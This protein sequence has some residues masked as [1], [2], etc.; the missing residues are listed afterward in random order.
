MCV[1]Q[2]VPPGC[3]TY[4]AATRSQVQST[5]LV[6][7]RYSNGSA[8]TRVD[9]HWHVVPALACR[10]GGR[11]SRKNGNSAIIPEG[12]A[13]CGPFTGGGGGGARVGEGYW[14]SA[15]D[16]ASFLLVCIKNLLPVPA[17][18]ESGMAADGCH[19]CMSV[20]SQG[21]SVISGKE[22]VCNVV[23]NHCRL[24]DE[25]FPLG[26]EQ[27]IRMLLLPPLVHTPSSCQINFCGLPRRLSTLLQCVMQICVHACSPM[28]DKMPS[29]HR[30]CRCLLEVSHQDGHLGTVFK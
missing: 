9:S 6:R 24:P 11:A 15:L 28:S 22:G 20:R 16:L 4:C 21:P 26:C 25:N 18:E 13:Q 14:G 7:G 23:M 29:F 10:V 3:S 12:W 30:L 19:T 5:L 2:I 1:T 17:K 27:C 8:V